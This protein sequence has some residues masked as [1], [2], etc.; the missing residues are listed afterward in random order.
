LP[1]IGG[2]CIDRPAHAIVLSVDEESRFQA[3][4][5][6]EPRPLDVAFRRFLDCTKPKQP[7]ED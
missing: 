7:A 1:D 2:P 3:L 5:R 4:D 6:K